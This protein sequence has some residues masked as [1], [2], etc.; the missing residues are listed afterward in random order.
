MKA[1]LRLFSLEYHIVLQPET[2]DD[3]QRIQNLINREFF[4]SKARH[5]RHSE[6]PYSEWPCRLIKNDGETKLKIGDQ[7]TLII[8]RSVYSKE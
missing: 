4:L 3:R 6:L 2:E 8:D 5:V 7:V 1:E